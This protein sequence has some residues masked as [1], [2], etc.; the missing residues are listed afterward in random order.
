[1]LSQ[2][3]TGQGG[4][5]P[6]ILATLALLVAPA[7]GCGETATNP[8]DTNA[9]APA[10]EWVS[11]TVVLT[12]T[13]FEAEAIGTLPSP[14]FQFIGC[15]SGTTIG[16][17]AITARSGSHSLRYS[18]NCFAPFLAGVTF[19]NCT[20]WPTAARWILYRRQDVYDY[21]AFSMHPH[22]EEQEP[23][24]SIQLGPDGG[25]R[26]SSDGIVSPNLVVGAY[27]T[28]VWTKFETA[29]DFVGGTF[30]LYIDDSFRGT[31]PT[32]IRHAFWADYGSNIPVTF[33]DDDLFLSLDL[34]G[35]RQNCGEL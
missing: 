22:K 10:L 14:F 20:R 7:L 11:T 15:P 25:V 3:T 1:M 8:D 18:N 34:R 6:R 27:Q 12:Q 5:R 17:S 24:T 30:D 28:G 26:V 29:W 4:P 32:K 21:T 13:D 31:F 23:S 9:P 16:V 33:Y 35:E 2:A 19:R